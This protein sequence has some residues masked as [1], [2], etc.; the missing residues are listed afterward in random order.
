M[1]TGSMARGF[2]SCT[3]PVCAPRSLCFFPYPDLPIDLRSPH[4]CRST[5]QALL[6]HFLPFLGMGCI[7]DKYGVSCRLGHTLLKTVP[8][9]NFSHFRA[10]EARQ[11]PLVLVG[12]PITR[13]S[14][15]TV[16]SLL[17]VPPNDGE[18]NPLVSSLTPPS[19]P[20]RVFRYYRS[21]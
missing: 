19:C 7:Q 9:P 3:S 2:G 13:I 18:M 1:G 16:S 10:A 14:I 17:V 11:Q 15:K 5:T 12:G 6:R 8:A 4:T 20:G 21:P